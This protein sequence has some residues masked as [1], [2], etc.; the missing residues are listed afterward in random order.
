MQVDPATYENMTLKV[1]M[2]V[3]IVALV[4]ALRYVYKHKEK[5]IK[6]KDDKILE[7][8]KHHQDDLKEANNDYK[9]IV[10][11]YHLFTQQIKEVILRGGG[12]E[13]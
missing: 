6:E 3:T 4:Y 2:A 10:D 12:N 1:A 13:N 11:N 8:I 5:T 7:I 9:R